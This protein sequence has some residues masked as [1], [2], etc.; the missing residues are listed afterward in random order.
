MFCRDACDAGASP[1]INPMN[2]AKHTAVI[3]ICGVILM[4]NTTSLNDIMLYV[5]VVIPLNGS[6]NSGAAAPPNNDNTSDSNTND[7]RMLG[8]LN[9]ITLSVAISLPRYAP[10]AYIV[11]IAAKL[12]PT[13]M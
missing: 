5:P 3:T 12:D 2:A 10:A 9:P 6:I 8:R 7:V 1:P 13:A 11:F 4:L